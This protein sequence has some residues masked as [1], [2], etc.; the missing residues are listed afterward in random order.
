[1]TEFEQ[2]FHRLRSGR[3][4]ALLGSPSCPEPDGLRTV[5]VD[6]ASSHPVL[7]H[8]RA[9]AEQ[10]GQS[11]AY[12]RGYDALAPSGPRRHL[13]G[14]EVGRLTLAPY[15]DAFDRLTAR[16]APPTAL[17]LLNAD[18]ADP[19]SV[20]GLVALLDS[21]ALS[22]PTLFCFED[23]EPNTRAAPLLDALLRSEGPRAI[24]QVESSS[25]R[26]TQEPD[27][28]WQ[29]A[30]LP[31]SRLMLLRA[32]ATMG[33]NFESKALSQLLGID[34]LEV[35]QALQEARDLGVPIEDRGRGR[36]RMPAKICQQLASEVLPSLASAWHERLAEL[37]GGS[38]EAAYIAAPRE[39]RATP[40]R[41]AERPSEARRFAPEPAHDL[42]AAEDVGVPET[43]VDER[44]W[45]EALQHWKPK[46]PPERH[47]GEVRDEPRAAEHAKRAGNLE[48]AAEKYARAAAR[49]ARAGSHVVAGDYAERALD[50][51]QEIPAGKAKRLTTALALLSLG[52]ARW[53]GAGDD[54]ASLSGALDALDECKKLLTP[55]DPV[56]LRAELSTVIADVCYDL[57]TRNALERAL[58]ELSTSSKELLAA[59]E[60]LEAARLLNDEAA[61]WVRLGDPVRGHYL[62]S[63]SREVFRRVIASYP[64]AGHELAQTD[65]ML[66]RLL[67]SATPRPGREVDALTLGIEHAK[68]AEQAFHDLHDQRSEGRVWETLGRLEMRADHH[69]SAARYLD[70]AISLQQELGDHV[71]LARSTG[72]LAELLRHKGEST[73]ALERLADSIR[74]NLS[75]GS[76][77]GLTFNLESLRA[78]APELPHELAST[79]RALEQDLLQR[80]RGS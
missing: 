68:N 65:H 9:L 33:P 55:E 44:L 59:H 19:A 64:A 36:F 17:V 28:S 47:A 56:S 54:G 39:D 63:Q 1:M 11:G 2:I 38:P 48:L 3:H 18:L 30:S 22:V 60:P 46:A 50:L 53:Q 79:A 4:A 58:S 66:A 10:L 13:I 29:P 80:L 51:L 16:S 76:R 21:H 61:I 26:H 67:L 42:L 34:E 37:Y 73:Q 23:K 74:H 14:E 43:P 20:D 69:E 24:Y 35:L 27:D 41:P 49:A 77:G 25:A 71:G 5:V 45:H 7:E 78:L 40:S 70:R 32:A 15:A 31:S 62:L 52:R 6:C 75:T 12:P 8:A 72:A 57:G